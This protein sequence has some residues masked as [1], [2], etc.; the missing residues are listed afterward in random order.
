MGNL[1]SIEVHAPHVQQLV[2]TGDW[3]GLVRYWMAHHQH[4][5]ALEEAINLVDSQARDRGRWQHL[6]S[7][8]NDVRRDPL[9]RNRKMTQN[10]L[11]GWAPEE[12]MT[13]ALVIFYPWVKLCEQARQAP[14]GMQEPMLR[15]GIGA[16]EAALQIVESLGDI[17]YRA[18]LLTMLA[19][20][21]RQLGESEPALGYCTAALDIYRTLETACPDVWRPEVAQLLLDL[22]NVQRDLADDASALA[23][24]R[25]SL[26]LYR[27]LAAQQ[28]EDYREMVGLSL[29]K[30]GQLQLRLKDL[31]AAC[32]SF[33]EAASIYRDLDAKHP[34]IYQLPLAVVL[35]NLGS[36]QMEMG[37]REAARS[38]LMEAVAIYRRLFEHQPES[39]RRYLAS[40]LSNLAGLQQEQ[41]EL[42]EALESCTIAT[43]VYGGLSVER[44]ETYWPEVAMTLMKLGDLQHALNQWEA[45]RDTFNEALRLRR[46]LATRQ[47]AYWPEVAETLNHLGM[48]QNDLGALEDARGSYIEALK[49]Y[50]R[51]ATR[52]RVDYRFPLATV[53]NNLGNTLKALNDWGAAQK[54]LH[55]ALALYR[56]LASELPDK[57]LINVAITLSNLGNLQ[58]EL[59]QLEV[60]RA[61]Y[62]EA[63]AIAREAARMNPE[64]HLSDV[65]L[66]LGNLGV[67][68]R[69]L[70][71][72][73]QARDSYTEAMELRRQ[74]AVQRPDVH[75]PGIALLRAHLGCVQYDLNALEAAQESFTE[76]L[77]IYRQLAQTRPQSYQQEVALMLSHLGLVQRT[78]NALESARD[79]LASS[80]TIYRELASERRTVYL[81][82]VAH[83][84]LNLGTV[85]NV[86]NALQ[87]AQ[88]A[89]IETLDIYRELAAQYPEIHNTHV[90][91]AL[92]EL[93]G[94]Q[95]KLDNLTAARDN[96]TESVALYRALM[97]QRPDAIRP[98]F[99]RV[100]TNLSNVQIA[101]G[102]RDAARASYG[103]ALTIYHELAVQ[104]PEVY[105]V[106]LAR[107]LCS[108]GTEQ[109]LLADEIWR[110]SPVDQQRLLDAVEAAQASLSEGAR[111]LEEDAAKHPVA[112][113]EERIYCW[114][115]LGKLYLYPTPRQDLDEARN[116]RRKAIKCL[117]TF[118]GRFLAFQQRHRVQQERLN[119]Y[120]SQFMICL[121]IW[122]K[123]DE[124]EALQEA[125][126]V[127][128]A[129]RARN[130]M[131][132][133]A[134]EALR[135]ANTPDDLVAQFCTLRRNIR[136]AERLLQEEDRRAATLPVTQPADA[137]V[138]SDPTRGGRSPDLLLAVDRIPHAHQ[139]L[140]RLFEE[141]GQLKHEYE[142]AL[143]LIRSNFDPLF[144]PDQPIPSITFAA[145]RQLIPDDI[146]SAIVQY[147]FNE[148]LGVALVI[149]S[150]QIKAV[151]LPGLSEPQLSEL[152]S[153]W[154]QSYFVRGRPADK[155]LGV[156]S[157]S[158]AWAEALPSFLETLAWRA[159]WPVFKVL[160]GQD[161]QRL[162]LSPNRALHVFPL[163]ACRLAD[164]RCLRG[165]LH[166][167]PVDPPPLRR[168]EASGAESPAPGGEPDL[169]P[170]VHRGRGRRPAPALSGP[171]GP[172]RRGGRQ[173]TA[174]AQRRRLS[175]PALHRPR[176]L[177]PPGPAALGTGPRRQGRSRAVADAARHL[178]RPAP[179]P[180][181]VDGHQRLRERHAPAG[182]GGRVRR[183]AQRL[184][185]RGCGLRAQ[186]P[187]GRVRHLQRPPDGPLPY[188]VARRQELRRGAAGGPALA[189][190]GDRQRPVPPGSGPA[191]PPRTARRRGPASPVQTD[192]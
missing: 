83:S 53:S 9:A 126:E 22:G 111:L 38:N 93:A 92:A 85:L 24:F 91:G 168:P 3:A 25:E 166:P 98:D 43:L 5:Q 167:Q 119:L 148:R 51:A 177:R 112:R 55:E 47:E 87:E 78:L 140:Q 73:E 60:S 104:R 15:L 33:I 18:F 37:D 41:N 100:L 159:V 183:A 138:S 69:L 29:N 7:F 171:H 27:Q 121:G 190:R 50:R 109:L 74:L 34:Q 122:L 10:Q 17:A 131:E 154:F 105:R 45:A 58:R 155:D 141:I 125:F 1:M 188:R 110:N 42:E 31:Q 192:G 169:R 35:N 23:S 89:F 149:T 127:A 107:I 81:P 67:V 164:G 117:E 186:H 40:A 21:N 88:D 120:E 19:Q 30:R 108:I 135:P 137:S 181:L 84:L 179:A 115:N 95:M 101:L 161:I 59:N 62:T 48:V 180:E 90:A 68:Q 103:E 176:D 114:A 106:D 165:G 20:G 134:D 82:M 133:L 152:A 57:Y 64:I 52:G 14:P 139:R 2:I 158:S 116:N 128:E 54:C 124:P 99:A 172:Q 86:M 65:A 12:Q 94:V 157:R 70:K 156:P 79:N 144:N 191:R 142:A 163:H 173:G 151:L 32:S 49:L 118:R 113:L 77:S 102:D 96:M 16:A 61:S 63:L 189:A 174:P 97:V 184:P 13:L 182:P 75:R 187:V 175:R 132:L 143:Q 136:Q 28:P 76:A 123:R 160:A 129:S 185:L 80:V 178:L 8:L 44:P 26:T 145:A 72:M 130:L 150:D 170:G 153:N 39:C 36:T 162:I 4:D 146:P 46:Q 56:E 66:I 71:D 6:A 11:Q 147:T